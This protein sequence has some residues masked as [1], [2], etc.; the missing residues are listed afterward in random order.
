[1][2][3]VL[4]DTEYDLQEEVVNYTYGAEIINDGLRIAR[5]VISSDTLCELS[6]DVAFEG[7]FV[8][9]NMDINAVAFK[10]MGA[11]GIAFSNGFFIRLQKWLNLWV[12]S[13]KMD[14]VTKIEKSAQDIFVGNMFCMII[15]FVV[16][17]E[18]YHILN[19]HCDIP[20][21]QSHFIQEKVQIV[22]ED[23]LFSQSLEY[24]ADFCAS[25]FCASFIMQLN[26]T[27]MERINMLYSFVLGLYNIFILFSKADAEDFDEFM[28]DDL[29][30]FDHPHA[31]V[32]FV[33]CSVAVAGIVINHWSMEKIYDVFTQI[34]GNC[35]AFDRILMESRHLKECLYSV[36]YT[37]KGV[38][39]IML[40][41][42]VWAETSKKLRKYAHIELREC[43]Y[44]DKMSYFIGEDGEFVWSRDIVSE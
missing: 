2:K 36:A 14:D 19:G 42:N 6:K 43:D 35:V 11:Y 3:L 5:K 21:N 20:E 1:M 30:L 9:E 33:Y 34:I 17:H 7:I 39:H 27:D 32:R 26:C 15:M 31:G 23:T 16:T 40:L 37:K 44:L 24:D 4:N 13:P 10:E 18:Y 29:T 41:N 22:E 8:Y 28:K 12:K 38:Q 25:C